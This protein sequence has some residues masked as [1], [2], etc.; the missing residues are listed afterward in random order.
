[1][2]I[3]KYLN[4]EWLEFLMGDE[5]SRLDRYSI[6]RKTFPI[7]NTI[8]K[9]EKHNGE[10]GEYIVKDCRGYL[11]QDE[12]GREYEF[13]INSIPRRVL[14]QLINEI[15]EP[16]ANGD[17]RAEL[18]SMPPARL[19]ARAAAVGIPRTK[20]N[21]AEVSL[22]IVYNDRME[23]PI[24]TNGRTS[25]PYRIILINPEWSLQLSRL[26]LA[27]GKSLND[28]LGEHSLLKDVPQDIITCIGENIKKVVG[29]S[30][31]KSEIEP[32]VKES[33]E[34]PNIFGIPV[35]RGLFAGGG[36]KRKNRRTKRKHRK[37]TNKRKSK[38]KKHK[39]KRRRKS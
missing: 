14:V 7:K 10:M 27:F 32:F 11:D 13:M 21:S 6:A 38:Q 16:P 17:R 1:M 3:P 24:I 29:E 34:Y 39:T 2:V 36:K 25:E 20:I 37:K 5:I 35:P 19:L 18:E 22:K 33:G 8:L 28:R 4:R 26:R 12:G 30:S 9:L 15:K 23:L 31:L